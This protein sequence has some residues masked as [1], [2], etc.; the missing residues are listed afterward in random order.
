MVTSSAVN[1]AASIDGGNRRTAT[2]FIGILLA[3]SEI[4][5]HLSQRSV[6]GMPQLTI[7]SARFCT[8]T[9]AIRDLVREY[10]ATI[11][12]NACRDEVEAGLR[13]L[14]APYDAAGNGFLLATYGESIAGGVAF[15]RLD[16]TAAEMAR[17]FVRPDYR[18]GGIAR[19]LI[20]RAL[21]EAAAAGYRR[22]VLHT[23]P[24]WRAA[25]ALYGELEFEPIPPYAG[26]GV[27]EAVCYARDL[28]R[29]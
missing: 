8:D 19:A 5:T 12:E 23:L 10:I 14:P 20:S 4:M 27:A 9:P 13:A 25:R 21:A 24:D 22:M 3:G 15:A 29:R 18:R 2:I 7:R 6:A 11:D 1:L 17:L 16:D 26:V 28:E